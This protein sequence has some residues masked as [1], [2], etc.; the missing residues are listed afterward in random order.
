VSRP[1]GFGKEGSWDRIDWIYL[2][3]NSIEVAIVFCLRKPR[4]IWQAL[5][6]AVVDS[7]VRWMLLSLTVT[8][9][10]HY[11]RP[12]GKSPASQ[13]QNHHAGSR[14]GIFVNRSVSGS[15]SLTFEKASLEILSLLLKV[16]IT[17]AM[18]L[19]FLTSEC[20]FLQPP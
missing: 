10:K 9:K 16:C 20:Y 8:H 14:A 18:A 3:A 7:G 6:P 4:S 11:R 13:V 19:C 5:S 17:R 12:W 15:P 1:C 2:T